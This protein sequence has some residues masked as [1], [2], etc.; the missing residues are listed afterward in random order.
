[1]VF[2]LHHSLRKLNIKTKPTLPLK[3]FQYEQTPFHLAHRV[4]LIFNKLLIL[5]NL[6]RRRPKRIRIRVAIHMSCFW[7][8]PL[9][10]E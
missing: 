7:I 10:F 6:N 8:G 1:M 5:V 4:L 2:F 3:I 9:Q